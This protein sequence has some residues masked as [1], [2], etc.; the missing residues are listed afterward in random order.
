MPFEGIPE[1]TKVAEGEAARQQAG[2]LSFK[3]H[4]Q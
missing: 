2:T 4:A 1:A 3:R